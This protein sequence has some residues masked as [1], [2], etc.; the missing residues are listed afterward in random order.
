[1][2]TANRVGRPRDPFIEGKLLRVTQQLIAEIGID[3]L[4]MNRVAERAGAS[5]A[6]LYRRWDDKRSLVRDAVAAFDVDTSIPNTGALRTDLEALI[7]TWVS[8]IGYP[9]S[10]FRHV[11]AAISRD[12]D[13]WRAFDAATHA[14]RTRALTVVVKRAVQR[15]EAEPLRYDAAFVTR[16]VHA[17]AVE[18]AAQRELPLDEAFVARVIESVV[19]PVLG[20]GRHPEQDAADAASGIPLHV[21]R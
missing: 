4:T 19:E 20:V 15:G 14:E 7:R 17:L 1:M 5:K 6:T 8:P 2:P 18:H 3:A 12:P 10:E 21:R 11:I 16:A 9:P 13:I